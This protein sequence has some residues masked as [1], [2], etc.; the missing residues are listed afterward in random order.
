MYITLTAMAVVSSS[1]SRRR[2]N[3]VSVQLSAKPTPRTPGRAPTVVSPPMALSPGSWVSW[4]SLISPAASSSP[5]AWLTSSVMNVRV[6]PIRRSAEAR[7]TRLS[8]VMAR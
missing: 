6:I 5:A 3:G 7:I 8:T 2:H 4:A 1:H